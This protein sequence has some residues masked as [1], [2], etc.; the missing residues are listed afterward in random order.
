MGC[1]AGIEV[2]P[3]KSF[4]YLYLMNS[5][6]RQYISDNFPEFAGMKYITTAE[7]AYDDII[8]PSGFLTDGF[9]TQSGCSCELINPLEVIIHDYGYET[10]YTTKEAIDE[11]LLPAYRRYYNSIMNNKLWEYNYIRGSLYF[12]GKEFTVHNTSTGR[13]TNYKLKN[14]TLFTDIKNTAF[15]YIAETVKMIKDYKIAGDS[16]K[17]HIINTVINTA[18]KS[19]QAKRIA[20]SA[21]TKV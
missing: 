16:V 15:V 11:K 7:I 21:I 6:E 18:V 12:N 8:I 14:S 1:C 4:K 13:K 2:S 9:T 17:N 3:L 10:H 19:P 5:D 20:K